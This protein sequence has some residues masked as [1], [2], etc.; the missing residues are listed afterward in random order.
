M[1]LQTARKLTK[2]TQMDIAQVLRTSQSYISFLEAGLHVPRRKH[3]LLIQAV[4]G[5]A[6]DFAGLEQTDTEVEQAIQAFNTI[7]Q[8]IGYMEALTLF[9]EAANRECL[10]FLIRG[11]TEGET[12]EVTQ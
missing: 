3:A 6:V 7:R 2:W 12:E 4:L 9:G 10:Q 5:Q 11:V 8:R 1:D